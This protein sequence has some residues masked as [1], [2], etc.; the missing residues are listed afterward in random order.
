MPSSRPVP[1]IARSGASVVLVAVVRVGGLHREPA[2]DAVLE[3][4]DLRQPRVLFTESS[5]SPRA[6][7]RF[8]ALVVVSLLIRSEP[9]CPPMQPSYRAGVRSSPVWYEVWV[10][11]R[12]T[13]SRPLRR[14]WPFCC[15]RFPTEAWSPL[16]TSGSWVSTSG[17]APSPLPRARRP[18]RL[19]GSPKGR[20]IESFRGRSD[21]RSE[22]LQR[23]SGGVLDVFGL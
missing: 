13:G 20:F 17:P 22:Q 14:P 18:L 3:R 5:N 11:R 7:T 8:S 10:V 2:A 1:L 4:G 23:S 12:P 21:G 9:M 15:S 16:T 19:Q 6:R